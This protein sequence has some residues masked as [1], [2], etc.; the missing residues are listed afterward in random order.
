MVEDSEN[1]A[2]IKMDRAVNE[3][4]KLLDSVI[5]NKDEFKMRQLAELAI[6]NDKF[7]SQGVSGVTQTQLIS[8][9]S[10]PNVQPQ[11]SSTVINNSNNN[12][13][14]VSAMTGTPISSLRPHQ[15]RSGHNSTAAAAAIAAFQQATH[16]AHPGHQAMVS[17]LSQ[18]NANAYHQA[19]ALVAAAAAAAA[20]QP[21]AIHQAFNSFFGSPTAAAFAPGLDASGLL[22]TPAGLTAAAA[23]AAAAASTS[24]S[25]HYPVAEAVQFPSSALSAATPAATGSSGHRNFHRYHPYGKKKNK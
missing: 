20:N 22:F 19:H 14:T 16:Q 3:I 10:D 7:K 12:S 21:P 17:A 25:L 24:S 2:Q 4:N 8:A 18:A 5:S 23:A 15:F 6:L 9:L 11:L 1:R 13:Q